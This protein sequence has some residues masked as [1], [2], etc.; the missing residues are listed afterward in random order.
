MGIEMATELSS[1][2]S[3]YFPSMRSPQPRSAGAYDVLW[4]RSDPVPAASA[5]GAAAE[6]RAQRFLNVALA[7]VG[8]VLAVPVMLV[9]ALAIKLSTRRPVFYT[10]VRIGLDRRAAPTDDG[11]PRRRYDLGGRPFDIY[12]FRTMTVGAER[13]TGEVWASPDDVRVTPIGRFLRR[14]RLD[15]L[16]QLLN[17]IKG[18]MNI[19]GPRPERPTI[20]ALLR[21]SIADYPKRQRARPGI[22]GLAQINQQYDTSLDDVRRKVR[23]DLEYIR[24]RS[25]LTDLRIMLL[26]VPTVLYRCQ[27]W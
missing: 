12:K 19:V 24:N 15:E 25:V 1:S 20:F 8:L 22:T 6:S 5:A 21:Q 4:L 23:F 13:H 18:D 27:G 16:P 11:H 3:I 7:A 9:I 2:P 26:S 14:Y 17:V 10:Q